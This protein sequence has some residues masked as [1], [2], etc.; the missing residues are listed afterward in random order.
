VVAKN[1]EGETGVWLRI[2]VW[3][4]LD[5]GLDLGKKATDS[6]GGS[7]CSPQGMWFAESRNVLGRILE[8]DTVSGAVRAQQLHAGGGN[9]GFQACHIDFFP[10]S[11]HLQ[12]LNFF[13]G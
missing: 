6:C 7:N 12:L 13:W 5:V 2:R 3:L 8:T 11:C 9:I 1:Q 10:S 4:A